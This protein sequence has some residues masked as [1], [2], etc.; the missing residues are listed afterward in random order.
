MSLAYLKQIHRRHE[1]TFIKKEGI[2]PRLKKIPVLTLNCDEDF[3]N[4]PALMKKHT[5]NIY[6]FLMQTSTLMSPKEK[7]LYTVAP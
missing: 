7:P 4:N 5:E 1:S 6:S 3:E 2:L